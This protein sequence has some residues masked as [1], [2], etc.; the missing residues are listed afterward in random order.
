[1]MANEFGG[2]QYP[3]PPASLVPSYGNLTNQICGVVGSVAGEAFV[4]GDVYLDISYRY[5]V[6]HKWRNVGIIIGFTAIL[7]C[8]YL[9]AAE[10]VSPKKSKGE[11]LVFPRGKTPAVLTHPNSGDLESSGNSTTKLEHRD[12]EVPATIQRQTAI[13]Q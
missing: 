2:R 11:V 9:V 8:A 12:T 4:S 13:F 6:S 1:M 5:Y 3:C 10:I 7:L